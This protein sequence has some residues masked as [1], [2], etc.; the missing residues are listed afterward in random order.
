MTETRFRTLNGTFIE[1][2]TRHRNTRNTTVYESA[3]S[4]V[5]IT[6]YNGCPQIADT[7]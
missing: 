1:N 2:K 7:R 6:C 4:E 5:E 3:V